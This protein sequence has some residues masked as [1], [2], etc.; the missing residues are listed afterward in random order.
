MAVRRPPRAPLLV[1]GV[2]LAL[3]ACRE[4]GEAMRAPSWVERV[5]PPR[6]ETAGRQPPLLV[7]L[8]GIGA[9]ENDLFPLAGRLDPRLRIVSLRAPHPYSGGWA[10]FHIDFLPG[11]RVVPDAAQA[12]EALADLVRWL[13]EAPA[14]LGTDPACTFLLGFSQGAM[15]A[16]RA[17]GTIPDRLA[18]VV[19]L[20]GR[21]PGDFFP[22]PVAREAMAKV[23][24]L[25][26]HGTLDDVLPIAE[27]RRT[28]AALRLVSRDFTYQEF[29]IGHGISEEEL[30]LVATW[31]SAH[32]GRE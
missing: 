21:F 18:G 31:L 24:L 10:W 27:G 3:A 11:G 15:M 19:A 6:R 1:L 23:P 8:H 16:L 7:L 20:S 22:A 29:P 28:A 13:A 9:D 30:T 12:K 32:L 5:A 26:T 4:G 2:V 17:L 25:V 14:R